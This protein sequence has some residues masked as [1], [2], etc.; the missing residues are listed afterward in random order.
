MDDFKVYHHTYSIS[1][2]TPQ[3]YKI[4]KFKRRF[5]SFRSSSDER[6]KYEHKLD[7]SLSR[8]RSTVLEIALCNKWDWFCT[9]TVDPHKFDRSDLSA[10]YSTFS[11]WLRD[12]RR[13]K[14][15]DIK[16]L[17]IPELHDDGKSWHLHGLVSG[18]FPSLVSF[19][20]VDFPVPRYLIDHEFYY[21]PEYS[22]KFGFASF[23]KVRSPV[24]S[25]FYISKYMTKDHD[26]LVSSLG[27]KTFYVS[28]GLNR[29]VQQAAIYGDSAFLDQFLSADYDFCKVGMTKVSD[30]LDWSFGLDLS[31]DNYIGSFEPLFPD[32]SPELP[33]DQALQL[34]NETYEQLDFF[35]ASGVGL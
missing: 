13:D 28:R 17:F 1:Q 20:S 34:I 19:R 25:A 9:L 29:S 23:A 30:N 21:W 4:V 15:L 14:G 10:F 24:R 32:I 6:K 26:R 33:L 22:S 16:Y 7:H 8:T 2:F 12:R 3:I 5:C 35:P 31:D 18:D 11:Q 27:S